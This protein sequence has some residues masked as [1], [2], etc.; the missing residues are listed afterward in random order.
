MKLP[1]TIRCV[2]SN[3]VG[4]PLH[5]FVKV[6]CRDYF[7]WEF[8]AVICL[9]FLP[10]EFAAAICREN[11]LWLFPVGLFCACQQAFFMCEQILFLCNQICFN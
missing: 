11:L 1:F 9:G 8:A 10:L 4:T 7:P 3:I 2:K 6:I 5:I